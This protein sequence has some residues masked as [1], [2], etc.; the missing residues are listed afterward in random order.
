VEEVRVDIDTELGVRGVERKRCTQKW[1]NEA[2]SLPA[3]MVDQEARRITTMQNMTAIEVKAFVPSKDFAL[4]KR[5]Y[6]DLGFNLAWSSDQLAYLQHGNS[7][8]LLQNFYVKEHADNFMMHLLVEDV[9][10]WW[11]HVQ[12]NGLAAKYGVR[13]DPP[14]DRPWGLRDFVV[15]DPTGV[16]WRIGQNI[17]DAHQETAG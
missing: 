3:T 13:V 2:G 17:I 10:S 5:F 1:P 16:L 7:S 8:F 12:D 6:Q 15:V 4:S 11:G 9:E 14:E